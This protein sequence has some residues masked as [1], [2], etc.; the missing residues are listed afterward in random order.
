MGAFK[1]KVKELW[2]K[3]VKWPMWK[4]KKFLSIAGGSVLAI[5]LLIILIVVMTYQIKLA[6]NVV[7]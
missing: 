4:S 5:V 2:N 7:C 3:I 1:E 6:Q